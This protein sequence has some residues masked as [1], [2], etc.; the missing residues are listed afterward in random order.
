MR[1]SVVEQRVTFQESL[2]TLHLIWD[3]K[4]SFAIYSK[5]GRTTKKQVYQKIFGKQARKQYAEQYPISQRRK[6]TR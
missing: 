1:E 4:T 3:D 5:K 6:S 2:Q